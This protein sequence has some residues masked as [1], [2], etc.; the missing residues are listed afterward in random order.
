LQAD[1]DES[2]EQNMTG[3]GEAVGTC[4]ISNDAATDFPSCENESKEKRKRPNNKSYI[5]AAIFV[6]FLS[7][8]AM[9]IYWP[10]ICSIMRL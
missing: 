9:N 8:L 1:E 3:E 7:I 6:L 10:D 2:S 4:N 5:F